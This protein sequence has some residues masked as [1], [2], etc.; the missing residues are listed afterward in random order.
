MHP[1]GVP[2]H[3]GWLS[4]GGFCVNVPTPMAPESTL[5]SSLSS[6]MKVVRIPLLLLIVAV[7]AASLMHVYD[8]RVEHARRGTAPDVHPGPWGDLQ[9]WDVRLEQP[10]EYVGFEKT[11]G[12][13]PFWN[14]G[15]V[16]PEGVSGILKDS[17]CSDALVSA[18]MTTASRLPDGALVLR[19]SPDQVSSLDPEN[20]SKLYLSLAANPANRFQ[21]N[22]YY[23]TDGD[24]ARLFDE[25][26]DSNREAISLMK[27][28]LYQRNGFTYFSDPE[29][30]LKL[31]KTR[32]ERLKFLQSLTSQ[33]VVLLRLLIRPDADIDK[34]LNYWCLGMPGVLLKDLRSLLEAQQRLPDGGSVSVLYLLP[35]LARERLFT[36]PLPPEAGSA[37]KLPDCHWT[38]LNFFRSEPDPRLSDNAYASDFIVK[39]YYEVARPG[40]CGDLVLLLD[41]QNRVVHSAVYIAYDIVFTKNGINYAQPWVLMHER[42]MVGSFSALEPVK[43]A[44]FR[45]KGL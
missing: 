35:P 11:T 29:C 17:G 30:V 6:F 41:Q 9:S 33:N 45:R 10:L 1:P 32:E 20:R 24:V 19:P 14:F 39:N 36:S 40:V 34:P 4:V 44:Y 2:E 8:K 3:V 13:G 28:L 5:F 26:F 37:S 43:V 22:P 18:L 31:L 16:S 15:P 12:E 7:G 42:D 21:Q 27:R 25:K 38:A 23:I